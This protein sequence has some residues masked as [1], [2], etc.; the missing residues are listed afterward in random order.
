M[1]FSIDSSRAYRLPLRVKPP[2]ITAGYL[3]SSTLDRLGDE[4]LVMTNFH[5]ENGR[6]G[7]QDYFQTHSVLTHF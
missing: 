2:S 3:A 4:M 1:S 5:L 6:L 7:S